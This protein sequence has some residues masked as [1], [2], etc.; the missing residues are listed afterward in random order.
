MA[1]GISSNGALDTYSY[2]LGNELVGNHAPEASIEITA[3]DFM[4]SSTVDVPVCIT[5][6]P[7]ELYH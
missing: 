3:F 1:Y 5:G 6:A 7:A 4:M 2:L